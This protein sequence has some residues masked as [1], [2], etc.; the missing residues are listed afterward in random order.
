MDTHRNGAGLPAAGAG[1]MLLLILAAATLGPGGCGSKSAPQAPPDLPYMLPSEKEAQRVREETREAI[2]VLP[3]GE[4]GM[5]G[6]DLPPAG[7]ST[8][9]LPGL[10]PEDD[11]DT[12][13]GYRVQV[14]A[15]SDE[16]LATTRAE[17]MRALFDEE[18]YVEFEGLLYKV[19]VGDCVSRDEAADLRR[20][21]LGMGLDGAFI[22]DTRVKAP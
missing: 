21:A 16:D 15:T 6:E 11:R 22:V 7:D 17:E 8:A 20:K 3:E 5:G 14:F 12:R 18:V 4:R 2:P 9:V 19:Q 10:S 13:F 1:A